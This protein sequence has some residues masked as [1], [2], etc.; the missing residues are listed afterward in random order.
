[1]RLDKVR[2]P[3]MWRTAQL[4]SSD[5]KPAFTGLPAR[6]VV[7]DARKGQESMTATATIQIVLIKSH[8]FTDG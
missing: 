3:G 1:M 5:S 6:M 7:H 4:G 8:L 2:N